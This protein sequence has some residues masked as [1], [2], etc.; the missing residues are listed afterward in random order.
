[1]IKSKFYICLILAL[2]VSSLGKAQEMGDYTKQEIK[3]FSQKVEDQIQFLEYFL[4][5]VGSEETPAR[6]KD[7]IITE[8]YKKI[9]RDGEVQVEDDLVMD[10]KV[11]TNKDI[12]AYLKD[13]EFF[14]KD[15]SFKFKVRKVEPF[16]R[17]NEEL[18]FI[19]SMDRTL[20]AT[21]LDNEKIENTK[22]RFVEVNLNRQSNELKIASIYTTKLS[23]D[24]EL[25]E[26][27]NSLSLGWES[28]FREK[29]E[30]VEDTV[31]LDQIYKI[32]AMDSLDL[33]GNDYI[34]DLYPIEA[35]RDLKYIN[36]SGTLIQELK[37]ISNV[38]YLAYLDVSNTPTEDIQFIKYSE[39]LVYLDISNT[40]I[41]NIDELKNLD[42]LKNLKANNTPLMSFA[43]MNDFESLEVLSLEKSGFNNLE[44]IQRL[45]NLKK[46]NIKRNYLINF[47]YL[48]ELTNLE[49][50]NL[51]QTNILDLSPL[52]ELKK[53]QV[54]NI[55]QT[56]VNS[57]EPLNGLESLKKLYADRTNITEDQADDFARKNNQ[58]LL[59]HNVENLQ[60]WWNT[61]PDGWVVVLQKI[62]NLGSSNMP[63]VE[64]ISAIVSMDSLDISNSEVISLRPILKFKKLKALNIDSTKIHDLS[65]LAGLKTLEK[66]S[67]N[68]SAVTNVEPL[69]NLKT[70]VYISLNQSQ[71]ASITPL[72]SLEKLEYL[73]V[74]GTEVPKWE[75]QEILQIVPKANVIFRTEELQFWWENL[76]SVWKDVFRKEFELSEDPGTDELH[77]LTST[78]NLNISNSGIYN[79]QPLGYF[80]N[81]Q[82]LEIRDVPL[83][84]ISAVT[85]LEYLKELTINQAPVEDLE[86]L[87]SLQYL[88]K[89]N[90]SNTGVEDLRELESL[91]RLKTLILSGTGVKRLKGLESLYDLRVLD[92]ASTDVRS[93]NPIH[94][95]IN[96][97]QLVCF[98]T[99]VN[100]RQINNFRTAN[101]ECDIKYY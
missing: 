75:V 25:Q 18:S 55:N 63:T 61:L 29:F 35:L 86:P 45:K 33:S 68:H 94:D 28:Y 59:I 26:W 56:E 2:L 41:S 96:L 23:R 48:G 69:K 66:L 30:I 21:G 39:E 72:R 17:D 57:L 9:F 78:R 43:S 65:P 99:R 81:L 77:K 7:V 27:W 83:S 90:L 64:E 38:T 79:L 44:S 84:D 19:V 32:S 36:I 20:T 24:K 13:V 5:T 98:N 71:I 80:I 46:L 12:T 1:M 67:G 58:V 14:F 53:L 34:Q 95:L 40:Q 100:N 73:D 8:S 97:E 42:K 10:R 76:E 15:A 4:N 51:E 52:K 22:P 11:I 3:D 70:M 89:L 6:D 91:A 92:I 60:T 31:S 50:V 74:D 62:G 85:Q 47:N 37:P 54:V 101:P 82:K 87:A 88:E 93:L 16:L 49:E